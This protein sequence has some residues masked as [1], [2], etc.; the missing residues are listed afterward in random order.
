[1]AIKGLTDRSV[2]AFPQ[3]GAF[4]K[5]APKPDRGPGKDLEYFRFESTDPAAVAA[6]EAAFGK[7]PTQI[8]CYLQGTTLEECFQ[9]C[10]EKWGASTLMH[11]CDGEW[12]SNF[13][14]LDLKRRYSPPPGVKPCPGGC[15]EVGR[16]RV[17]IPQL[18]RF[19][20]VVFETHSKWDLISITE[21]LIPFERHAQGLS[22]IPFVIS[23]RP[24]EISVPNPKSDTG[25]GRVTKSLLQIEAD[26]RWVAEQMRQLA[27]QNYLLAPGPQDQALPPL[28]A[29]AE[30]L[31]E[32]EA[33][34][35]DQPDRNLMLTETTNLIQ[36]KQVSRAYLKKW[37]AEAGLPA[38]RHEMSIDQL[39]QLRDHLLGLSSLQDAEV[40]P[41]D[42]V[43][44]SPKSLKLKGADGINDD[45]IQAIE[46]LK[47]AKGVTVEV[48]EQWRET[49]GIHPSLDRCT[50]IMLQK[51]IT[52][53][54]SQEDVL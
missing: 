5:G 37:C 17:I 3:I 46:E 12:C 13:Y 54:E 15:K 32:L 36:S 42:P 1:M 10:K 11:R 47:I 48:W 21:S 31:V 23:R 35:F 52:W 49:S 25:R 22:R 4:K 26:P 43:P 18:M 33:D 39:I 34:D 2:G 40:L 19:A 14:D 20:A 30:D 50:R 44:E 29:E 24:R 28:L 16:L 27:V 53:L 41:P 8:T 6:V 51:A 38:T 7:E 9:T 45:L